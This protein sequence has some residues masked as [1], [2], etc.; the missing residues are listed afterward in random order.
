[1]SDKNIENYKTTTMEHEFE[2]E[3]HFLTENKRIIHVVERAVERSENL[4]GPVMMWGHDLPSLVEIVKT[5]LQKSGAPALTVLVEDKS[6]VTEDVKK[7][8]TS[9]NWFDQTKQFKMEWIDAWQPEIT[10]EQIIE[11]IHKRKR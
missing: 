11:N 2:N 9:F 5:D 4:V 7:V 3:G 10:K 6:K 1:M 8:E